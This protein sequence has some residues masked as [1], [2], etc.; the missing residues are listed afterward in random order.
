M[1]KDLQNLLQ[2]L[3]NIYG[4]EKAIFIFDKLIAVLKSDR[5]F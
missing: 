5:A 3:I 4:K 2:A 1:K